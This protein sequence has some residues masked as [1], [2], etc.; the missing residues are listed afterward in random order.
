MRKLDR[1]TQKTR[2]AYRRYPQVIS[3]DAAL[4]VTEQG[5]IEEGKGI[6]Y[7]LGGRG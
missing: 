7:R 2:M 1:D 5:V 4:V 6:D 3:G